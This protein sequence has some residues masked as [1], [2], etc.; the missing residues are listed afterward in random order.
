MLRNASLLVQ[1]GGWEGEVRRK[2]KQR[3]AHNKE[4]VLYPAA[5]E[6]TNLKQE[7]NRG[8][9]GV[10]LQD[11]RP[12]RG[13]WQDGLNQKRGKPKKRWSELRGMWTN[14]TDAKEVAVLG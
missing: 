9:T 14:K 3:P 4:F 13:C 8:C 2:V 5:G 10:K 11:K 7:S 1:V 12:F 6:T